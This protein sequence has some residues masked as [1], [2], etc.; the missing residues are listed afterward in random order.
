MTTR[1]RRRSRIKKSWVFL[2]LVCLLT[3]CVSEPAILENVKWLPGKEQIVFGR[4]KVMKD[5]EPKELSW[6]TGFKVYVVPDAR[7]PEAVRVYEYRVKGD[8][9]FYW[10]LPP[11]GYLITEF[12]WRSS[13]VRLVS[14]AILAHFV[15]PPEASRPIYIGT[16]TIR[17]EGDRYRMAVEDEYVQT[18]TRLQQQ[19][20]GL[21][22]PVPKRLMQLEEVLR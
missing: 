14:R 9:T 21:T 18:L 8:G 3:S 6:W 20:R 2:L 12:Q 22:G 16:L 15:I 13:L 7:P 1:R 19:F 5:D 17:V 10:D 4:V 11:G